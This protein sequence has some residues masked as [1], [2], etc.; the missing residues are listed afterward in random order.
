MNIKTAQ[1]VEPNT[2]AFIVQAIQD[3]ISDPDFGLEFTEGAIRRLK[4]ASAKRIKTIPL[5]E[6]KKK[7]Y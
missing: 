7:Y 2:K 3:I 1:K 4:Q 5:S 6:I